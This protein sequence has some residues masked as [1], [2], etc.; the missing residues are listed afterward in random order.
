MEEISIANQMIWGLKI[1]FI[2]MTVVF[3]A[4]VLVSLSISIFRIDFHSLCKRK[5]VEQDKVENKAEDTVAT[6]PVPVVEDSISPEVIAAISAAVAVVLD[7][8][9][10]I[11]KVHYHKSHS[12]AW[13]NQ[14]IINIMDSHNIEVRRHH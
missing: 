1:A 4:L 8:A 11:K 5:K 2:G 13:K 6:S 10:R 12:S 3:S 9:Y 14:G 7:G